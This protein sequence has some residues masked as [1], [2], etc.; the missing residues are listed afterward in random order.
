MGCYGD[1]KCYDRSVLMSKIATILKS[2]PKLKVWLSRNLMGG[3]GVTWRVRIAK[4]VHFQYPRWR[5]WGNLETLQTKSDSELLKAIWSDSQDGHHGTIYADQPNPGERFWLTWASNFAKMFAYYGWY[6]QWHSFT[7]TCD[8]GNW[9]L[10][11]IREVKLTT[12]GLSGLVGCAVQME[13]RRSWV[14]PPLRS[15]T[16]FHGDWSWNIF[17]GH[18]LPSA[19]PRRAVVSFWQKNVHNTGKLL[20]GLKPCLVKRVAR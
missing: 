11:L 14:Q 7:S 15:A 5:N 16:F 13:T 9:T 2:S 3:T 18:S 6:V 4:I 20:R 8:M 17:Y 19:D 10:A 1:E 12:A